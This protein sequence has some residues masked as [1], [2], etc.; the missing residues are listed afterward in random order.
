MKMLIYS[1]HFSGHF[2]AAVAESGSPTA[3]IHGALSLLF[4]AH[5]VL[6]WHVYGWD[7][8]SATHTAILWH[9]V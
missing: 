2:Q 1:E 5:C 4:C 7:V 3:A 8:S 6:E 9:P